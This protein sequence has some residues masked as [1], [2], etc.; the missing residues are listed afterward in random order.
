MKRYLPL[1]GPLLAAL[2]PV[3]APPL[4]DLIAQNPTV[5]SSLSALAMVLFHLLP[6]PVNHGQPK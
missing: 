6:S 1:L 5:A 2:A 4:Q 3:I